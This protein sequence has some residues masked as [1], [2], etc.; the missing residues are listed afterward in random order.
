M[1]HFIGLG[2]LREDDSGGQERRHQDYT[3]K[4]WSVYREGG[5]EAT[6][7]DKDSVPG[8]FDMAGRY[9]LEGNR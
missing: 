3:D 2:S 7:S 6:F 1:G 5:K 9:T 8:T 4:M